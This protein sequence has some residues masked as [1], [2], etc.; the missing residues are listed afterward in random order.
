[1]RWLLVLAVAVLGACGGTTTE[2]VAGP[3]TARCEI[4]LTPTDLIPATG[5]LIPVQLVTER[6]CIWTI[7]SADPSITAAP[8]SGQGPAAISVAIGANPFGRVR[9]ASV[10]INE[11][12]FTFSQAASP[13]TFALTPQAIDVRTEG[14]RFSVNVTTLEGCTWTAVPSEAWVRVVSGSG[15][16]RSRAIELTIDSNSRDQRAATLQVATEIV[17]ILQDGASES[18]RGCP[19]SFERGSA[20][21]PAAGGEGSVRLHTRPGC[22]WGARSSESWLV[23]TSTLNGSGTDDIRYRAEPNPSTRTRSA[24]ITAGDRRHVVNQAGTR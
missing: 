11:Q 14:G 13:C 17:R 16:D 24:T 19:Y 9:T 20:N 18:A 10:T 22:S 7:S 6:D 8:T 1:M 3:T 2:Q 4:R 15:G 21:M 12:P 23:I 5:G